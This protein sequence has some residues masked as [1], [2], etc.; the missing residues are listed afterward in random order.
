M[1]VEAP[2][3]PLAE[4]AAVV[5]LTT[6]GAQLKLREDDAA[7]WSAA[8]LHLDVGVPKPAAGPVNGIALVVGERYRDQVGFGVVGFELDGAT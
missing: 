6:S 2:V 1:F 8:F 4:T 7:P 3:F 5:D